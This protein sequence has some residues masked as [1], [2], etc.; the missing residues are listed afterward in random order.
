MLVDLV[1]HDTEK[2]SGLQTYLRNMMG[3]MLFD[4]S[5]RGQVI[6]QAEL[7]KYSRLL[8]TAVTEAMHYFIGHN[9]PAPPREIRYLAVT[10]A[11]ITHMLRDTCEDADAGYFNIPSEYLQAHAISPLDVDHQMYREWVYRRVQLA[12]RYF[13]AGRECLAQT[14]S[15]RC[16][17]TGYAYTAR[18]EWVLRA[19][20]QDN[21]R[22]RPEY[23]ER[24]SPWAILGMIW[25]T[26]A[27]MLVS[28]P[29]KGQVAQSGSTPIHMDES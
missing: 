12:R 8:A 7:F 27:F 26:L 16:R 9:T 5:R 10:A 24:K 29:G 23:P 17:L 3:V 21:Y 28:P 20:E 1:S 11:H 4:A 18:F 15:L 22:L 6:T 2:D 13:Q 19:I 14:K 25:S